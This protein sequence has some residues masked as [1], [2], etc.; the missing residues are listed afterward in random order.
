MIKQDHILRFS[1]LSKFDTLI[2]G[3][4]TKFFGSM[5]PSQD[6]ERKSFKKFSDALLVDSEKVVRMD[7]VHADTVYFATEKDRGI[8]ISKTDGLITNVDQVFLGVITADCLPLLFYDPKTKSVGAVHAGW[9]GLFSEIIKEEVS[10]FI[11][12]GSDP[13]DI[14]VG[15]G[16]SIRVCCY[17]VSEKFVQDFGAKFKNVEEFV[18]PRKEKIFF[19]LQKVAKRQLLALEIVENNVEDANYCSYEH[20]DVHSCRKEGGGFGEMM[21][22]IGTK[23]FLD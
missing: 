22:I 10:T 19:D 7:Q 2:H 20:E 4:S 11:A 14:L 5:L 13:K 15:I 23:L 16:P 3:F 8:T 17:E 6:T 21:G 12:Q 1:N 18:E 9:R